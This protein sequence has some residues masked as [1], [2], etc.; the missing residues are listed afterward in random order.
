MSRGESQCEQVPRSQRVPFIEAW[1]AHHRTVHR[2]C[3][4]LT[5]SLDDADEAYSR[6]AVNAFQN[7]PGD[8]DTLDQAWRWLAVVARNVCTDLF[9]ER[10]RRREISLDAEIASAGD[11]AEAIGVSADV[12]DDY[13]AREQMHRVLQC[14]RQ[15]PRRLRRP[16]EL[17]FVGELPYRDVARHLEISEVNVR[18]RIQQAKEV[19]RRAVVEEP[20]RA[21]VSPEDERAGEDAPPLSLFGVVIESD[22]GLHRDA[23]IALPLARAAT[24]RQIEVL[25]AYA[26]AHPRGWRRRLDLARALVTA[27]AWREAVSHYRYALSRQPF[28]VQPWL[29]LGSV[30]A[31]LGAREEAIAVYLEGSERTSRDADRLQL[32]AR[33]A[34]LAGD[35]A[36]ASAIVRE[37]TGDEDAAVVARKLRACGELALERGHVTEAA[38]ALEQALAIDPADPLAR[39]L[40]HDALLAWGRPVA[41]REQLFEA[42]HRGGSGVPAIER[43]IA[44]SC[45]ART[46]SDPSVERLLQTLRDAAPRRAGTHAAFAQVLLATGRGEEAEAALR[47]SVAA[48]HKHAQAW[49]WLARIRRSIG[50]VGPGLMA[51]FTSLALDRTNREAWLTA[52]ALARRARQ[53]T[54]SRA[55]LRS[56]SGAYPNDPLVLAEAALL[57]ASTGAGGEAIALAAAARAQVPDLPRL[58][59]AHAKTLI[60]AGRDVDAIAVLRDAWELLPHGDAHEDAA[61]AALLLALA[62]RRIGESNEERA[63]LRVA[64]LRATMLEDTDPPLAFF[65]RGEAL[66][67]L[68][69]HAEALAAYREAAAHHLP[70]PWR[71]V[72]AD[73]VRRI[74]LRNS[75]TPASS[76]PED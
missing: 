2:R 48:N 20:R 4:I 45:R 75:Q 50:A 42:L 65:F 39:I 64:A 15:L 8:I 22:D 67:A 12:E 29:E 53:T 62:H 1:E 17:H 66:A 71:R 59:I 43:L 7:W 44:M 13:L 30:L 49:L 60:A 33:A 37:T 55:L 54:C 47:A 36:R 57:A 74:V 14:L 46:A 28:P 68:R 9:R 72:M 5:G 35:A 40:L 56:M 24:P 52:A 63:W 76:R 58:H 38:R 73:S 21:P 6:T 32:R 19:L 16:A 51:A 11:A 69:S 23:E 26:D 70:C 27:G 10:S 18:K 25:C 34:A 3:L 61:R 31:L 41:A